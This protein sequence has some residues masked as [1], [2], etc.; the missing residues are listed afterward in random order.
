MNFIDFSGRYRYHNQQLKENISTNE[1][2]KLFLKVIY[3][4]TVFRH[5]LLNYK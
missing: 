5:I 3:L 1:Q 4:E 2:T